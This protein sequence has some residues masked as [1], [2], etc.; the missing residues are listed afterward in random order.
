MTDD[1]AAPVAKPCP[2]CART[3]GLTLG[4]ALVAKPLG[5]WS[6]AG[7]QL[8]TSARLRAVLACSL[9]D[10]S[11]TGYLDGVTVRDGTVTGGHFV[12]DPGLE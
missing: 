12:A 8:K 2:W 3:G 11:A 5:T 9:C 1:G 10:R 6:L 4:T 7:A